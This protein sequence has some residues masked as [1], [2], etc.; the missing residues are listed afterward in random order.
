MTSWLTT[1]ALWAA[2]YYALATVLLGLAGLA[3]VRTSDPSRRIGLAWAAAVGLFVLA[4]LVAAPICP[5]LD[6]GLW[7]TANTA[8][9]DAPE[10]W[11]AR[12]GQ[13]FLIG[14]TLVAGWLLL[15]AVRAARLL[16]RS[17]EAPSGVYAL[18]RQLVGAR[19]PRLRTNDRLAQPVALGV[20]RPTIV[21]PNALET[22]A[23][24]GQ[25]THLLRH[26]WAHIRHG[27][28]WLLA[29]TRLLLLVLFAHPLYW[30][31]RSRIRDDQELLADAVAAGDAPVEYAHTLL[32][33]SRADGAPTPAGGL[34]F[35]ARPS[36]LKR[37]LAALL[38]PGFVRP[39]ARPG[40]WWLGVGTTVLCL[41][42]LLSAVTLRQSSQ[43]SVPSVVVEASPLPAPAA[44]PP[45]AIVSVAAEPPS[46]TPEIRFHVEAGVRFKSSD[47]K[48]ETANLSLNRSEGR[49]AWLI[50][51]LVWSEVKE[52]RSGVR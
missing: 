16:G 1:L 20:C 48:S 2:D 43:K 46:Q 3:V 25:L 21:L 18:L 47:D 31:L 50:L 41:V 5:R 13:A 8:G 27:D 40:A 14:T 35:A 6:L 49:P 17:R 12:L 28:L 4:A 15:G 39:A 26:E 45:P 42:L 22:E 38:D 30:W 44:S 11:T 34:A 37:R 52:K 29:L 24:R 10:P 51:W 7:E 9:A 19:P 23:T 32:R 33:W 36:R